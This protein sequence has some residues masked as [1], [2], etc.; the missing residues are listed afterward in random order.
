M[1]MKRT[2]SALLALCL[3]LC[4]A[5]GA[6]AEQEKVDVVDDLLRY[7]LGISDNAG[8]E[9][10]PGDEGEAVEPEDEAAPGDDAEGDAEDEPSPADD[11]YV[12]DDP[13]AEEE[14]VVEE[15][16]VVSDLAINESL[17]EDWMN[18]LLLGTDSR[19]ST[20]YL[21]TD[22][23]IVMS[24]NQQL[25]QAKLTS[26]MRDIW[27]QIPGYDGQKLN[28]ACV[29]G[30]PEL[31]MKMINQYFGLN[32]EY[33]AL[34]N[35]QCLV[36]I[37]ES[38][39]GIRLDISRGEAAAINRLITSDKESGDSNRKFA[40]SK[41]YSGSQ[42][43]LNGKQTLAYSRIRKSDSDYQRTER[44]RTVLVTIAKAMQQKSLFALAGIVT[45]LLQYV[46]T[47]MSF[48][49]IMAI[50]GVCMKMDLANLSEFRVPADGTYEDGMFGNTWCIK[51]D[52]EENAR[53]L[54]A[55]IYGE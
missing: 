7:F 1:K 52:F 43:L 49:Q 3:M 9:E 26:I 13:N 31:T 6:L 41:V 17:P 35:M 46:E 11:V 29:Y 30:G 55:F 21:R 40:T 34:V 48:D 15:P 50:A 32:L 12:Y 47:N 16:I 24:I 14:I 25:G 44:Q 36:E 45:G 38:L 27:I 10:A 2:V 19:G 23:M 20:K 4:G 33:Y 18:I 5:F 37:V 53:Q 51:P 54:K 39:G 22:T 42:V 28:A 8:Q